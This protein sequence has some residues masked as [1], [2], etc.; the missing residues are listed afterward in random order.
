MI[1]TSLQKRILTALVLGPLAVAGVLL[2][3]T[4]QFALCLAFLVVLGAWEWAVLAGVSSRIGR[5]LYLVL[6]SACLFLLW[7]PPRAWFT[8]F[9]VLTA[10]WWFAVAVYLFRLRDVK[11]AAGLDPALGAA[12]LIVL[13]GP[14]A[15]MVGLHGQGPNGPWLVLFLVVLI[16]TVD[17]AAYFSGRR[18]GRKK[19]APA[20][21]PGKTIEGVYGALLAA[22]AC[23]AVLVWGMALGLRAS[24]LAVLVCVLTALVSVVGDLFESL[25]KRRRGAKDSGRL[26]PGHGGILDRID[27]LTAAAPLFALGLLWLE[28]GV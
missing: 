19:L 15:A 3:T 21:S 26:L 10:L 12:G 16:W 9:L 27:S 18:W 6:T 25:L 17:S 14:W 13:A 5:V 28:A 23:G 2:L 7:Q 24:A 11:P 4:A 1:F 22:G 8:Y 20:L